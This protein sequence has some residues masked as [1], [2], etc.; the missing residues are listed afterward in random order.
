MP[1][2]TLFLVVGPSGAGKDSLIAGAQKA[3]AGDPR[4]VFARRVITRPPDARGEDHV[5]A[6]G[7]DFAA[8]RA[9]GGFML[10]WRAHGAEY[11]IP[12]GLADALEAGRHVVANV[13]RGIIA[14]ALAAFPPVQVIEVTAPF[15]QRVERLLGRGREPAA[16][17]G[18]RLA[19]RPA[20]L[21]DGAAV[22][23]VVNDGLLEEGTA[24]FLA[25]LGAV[26]PD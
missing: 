10:S 14:E 3:L 9:G 18:D 12:A 19:R 23:T 16:A 11:G 2:G 22:V 6:S 20:P 21:P 13:S 15:E 24:R 4:Y 1:R 26:A 25:A 7:E 17:I 8:G 5:A